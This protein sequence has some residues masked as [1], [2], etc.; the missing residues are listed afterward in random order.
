MAIVQLYVGH[1]G[2]D[3]DPTH[4]SRY[5]FHNLKMTVSVDASVIQTDLMS[6][7]QCF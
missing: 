1:A 4:I 2:H 3:T 5:F 6:A 7:L